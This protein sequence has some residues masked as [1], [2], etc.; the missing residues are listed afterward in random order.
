MI[1]TERLILRRPRA[2]DVEDIHRIFCD[3]ETMTY[4]SRGPH[5][6]LAETTEWLQ[7]LLDDPDGGRFD[8]FIEFEGRL[9]GKLGCW[10]VPDIGYA[11]ARD[12]WGRGIAFEAMQAFIPHIRAAGICNHLL[13][14]IDPRND[15][16]RRLLESCGFH[17]AGS[18]RNTIKTHLGWCDSDYYRLDFT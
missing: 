8:Y 6:D 15:R 16:S 2:D 14:D 18:A 4:W 10:R 12:W 1:Q 11:L 17:H 5:R 7:P 3:A 13:A 9:V